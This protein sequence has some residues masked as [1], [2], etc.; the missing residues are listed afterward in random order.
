[1]RLI[2]TLELAQGL[3]R[4]PS[5]TPAEGGALDLLAG[6]L[7]SL[8]FDCHRLVFEAPDSPPV[9]NLY[10][11]LGNGGPTFCYAGHTDVV[12]TGDL[13]AW[14]CDP[15]AAEVIDGT[16]YGRGAVDMKGAIAAFVSALS[17]FLAARGGDFGGSVSLLITGDEEGPAVNGTRKVL[18]WMT[19]RGEPIDACLVGEPTSGTA[20]GDT[21]KVGRR[22]AL[23]ARLT[24]MGVQGHAAYPQLADNPVHRLIAMLQAL[25]AEPLCQGSAHFEPTSLQ[26][27][28]VDVGNRATNVIPAEAR[29]VFDVRFSDKHD[30][31]SVVRWVRERLDAA[32]G[33]YELDLRVSGESFLCP[34]G[35]FRDLIANAVEGVVGRPPVLGT[36]GGTSDA[37]FIKDHCPVA[38]LGLSNATAHQVDERV[39]L[40]DLARL[41]AIY[42]AVLDGYFPA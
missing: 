38:E 22:G 4:C 7:T 6:E 36:G 11:R 29:A 21:V 26:V 10:A 37:R 27:T 15:F 39:G 25:T 1:M 2:D 17:Q 14:R 41:T 35:S 31:A 33:R 20:I 13:A 16:L 34:P 30:S 24:V 28:S 42:R 40:E 8:G 32:G 9:D 5:V 3:I 19:E 18:D 12:P 23:N